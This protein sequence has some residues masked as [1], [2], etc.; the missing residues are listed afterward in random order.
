LFSFVFLKPP[1]S[2]QLSGGPPEWGPPTTPGGGPERLGL[3]FDLK[4][5]F[6]DFPVLEERGRY[7]DGRS[8]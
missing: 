6:F 4:G 2:N 3:R 8:I 7:Y 5:N 1:L